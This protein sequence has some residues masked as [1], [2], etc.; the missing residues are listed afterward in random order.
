MATIR[1]VLYQHIKGNSQTHKSRSF[2]L[3]RDAIRKYIELSTNENIIAL[4]THI[5]LY[6]IAITIEENYTRLSQSIK[7]FQ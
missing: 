7:H 3:A 5:E 2:D 4:S 6:N 1:Q